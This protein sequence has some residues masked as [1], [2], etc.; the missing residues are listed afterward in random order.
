MRRVVSALRDGSW[1]T[2]RVAIP[3]CATVAFVHVYGWWWLLSGQRGLDPLGHRLGHDFAP[4]YAGSWAL[5]AGEAAR[6]YDLERFRALARPWTG[7]AAYAWF[8]PP[9][10]L[11]IFAP[12][13]FAPYQVALACSLLL[14]IGA[15][16]LALWIIVPR[17]SVLLVGA[18][19]PA[20]LHGVMYG[21]SVLLVLAG[22]FGAGLAILEKSPALGGALLGVVAATKPHLAILV[23]LALVAGRRWRAIGGMAMALFALS[24]ASWTAY[25]SGPW[26][27]FFAAPGLAR[28]LLETGRIPYSYL[29]S[30]FAGVRLLGGGVP[31]SFVFQGVALACAA[32]FVWV[33]WR[34]PVARP[35][36]R[37]MALLMG[38][39]LATPYAFEYDLVLLVLGIAFM[40]RS[41]LSEGWGPW[42]L[43]TAALAWG[44]PAVSRPVAETVGLVLCPAL[45][46][47]LLLLAASSDRSVKPGA[48]RLVVESQHVV[49]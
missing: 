47:A 42:E 7:D 30:V 19:S 16:M 2:R 5:H 24:A 12:L 14:G 6:L 11:P 1:V 40:A 20:L 22:L 48:T 26:I 27:A 15:Y 44:L 17:W 43:S 36:T 3:L 18:L 29:Q 39:L 37:A 33:A 32:G 25:G 4:L 45:L 31:L 10:S 35:G 8:Y 13:A 41:R 23:P 9:S 28:E 21:Q 38:S 34:P 49:Q 46:L